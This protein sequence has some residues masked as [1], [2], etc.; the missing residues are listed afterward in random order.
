MRGS[1]AG[2]RDVEERVSR[3]RSS[4]ARTQRERERG[5]LRRTERR[6]DDKVRALQPVKLVLGRIVGV[7][8]DVPALDPG[9][10]RQEVLGDERLLE[11]GA[12]PTERLLVEAELAAARVARRGGLV[13]VVVVVRGR[14][15]DGRARVGERVR[16]A[17][18]RRRRVLGLGGAAARGGGGR[19][20]G[21]RGD[22]VRRDVREARVEGRAREG[23]LGDEAAFGRWVCGRVRARGQRLE[24]GRERE[25]GSEGAREGRTSGL[26]VVVVVGLVGLVERRCGRPSAVVRACTVAGRLARG[27]DAALELSSRGRAGG[28]WVSKHASSRSRWGAGGRTFWRSRSAS[29]P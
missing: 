5:R 22:A 18:P 23:R 11:L 6:I 10:D 29:P 7:K 4:R 15:R 24:S 26:V 3:T 20:R 9:E 21:L 14:G 16:V 2:G 28:A 12:E 19:G 25:R 8:L 17:R 1:A 13:V 27:A